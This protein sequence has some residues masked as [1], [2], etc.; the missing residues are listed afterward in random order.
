[1]AEGFVT[2]AAS[3]PRPGCDFG[4]ALD[5][6]LRAYSTGVRQAIGEL[7]GG[8]RAYRV[9][10][11]A[12]SG[13][14][15]NQA[16]MAEELKLDRTIMTYLVDGLEADGLVTRTPDPSDRR[17]RHVTLTDRGAAL[18]A[19]FTQRV[20][21]VERRVLAALPDAEAESL[22]GLILKAAQLASTDLE[23]S[24]LRIG[25]ESIAANH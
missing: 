15:P 24:E 5:T 23:G 1:M 10:A 17:A 2:A 12:A 21:E 8:P 19:D 18:L 6:L 7:A 9:M 25:T 20:R 3:A 14:C 22:S 16:A 13:S 11:L 4:W